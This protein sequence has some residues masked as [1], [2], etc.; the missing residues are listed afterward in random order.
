MNN[1]MQGQD[2]YEDS[3][4][5]NESENQYIYPQYDYSQQSFL[6]QETSQQYYTQ[7]YDTGENQNQYYNNQYTQIPYSIQKKKGI[8]RFLPLLVIIALAASAA[9]YF[10][11]PL[12][13][14]AARAIQ[15]YEWYFVP[16]RGQCEKEIKKFTQEL[17]DLLENKNAEAAGALIHPH[18]KDAYVKMFK[19]KPQSM[20]DL[21]AALKTAKLSYLTKE[22]SSDNLK[23]RMAVVNVIFN[24]KQYEIELQK[25]NGKWFIMGI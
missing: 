10:N 13:G 4:Y 25:I 12:Q 18:K 24:G 11:R 17:A 8:A 21:A 23:G 3:N 15:K 19:A 14:F 22:L 1:Q 7:Q 5:L 2:G 9:I 16:G 20:T 6:Q